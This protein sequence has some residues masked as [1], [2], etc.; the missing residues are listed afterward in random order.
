MHAILRSPVE[1]PPLRWRLGIVR[2]ANE[3]LMSI[4][5]HQADTIM[6]SS[7]FI[8]QRGRGRERRTSTSRP[9]PRFA[10][11]SAHSNTQRLLYA[12]T[13]SRASRNF[14]LTAPI[15]CLDQALNQL[16]TSTHRVRLCHKLT[17]HP[18]SHEQ[19]NFRKAT[20]VNI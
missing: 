7:A 20:N 15:P 16:T 19:F 2:T 1:F 10:P 13:T 17:L 8:R 18:H 3:D 5:S 14:T 12:S 11:T 4:N 9:R 6:P